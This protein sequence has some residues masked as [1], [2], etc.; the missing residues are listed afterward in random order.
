M[1]ENIVASSGELP[2]ENQETPVQPPS[3]DAAEMDSGEAAAPNSILERVKRRTGAVFEKAGIVY[4]R[5]GGRPRKD[6]LPKISDIPINA[7]GTALPLDTEPPAP[8]PAPNLDP[9]LVRRCCTAVI[10]AAKGF[11]DRH[12]FGKARIAGLEPSEAQQL[13]VDTTITAE[14]ADAFSELAEI[15][16]RK[17]GVGSEFAPEVAIAAI[18]AGIGIRYVNAIERMEEIAKAK[19][20]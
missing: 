17:Y 1:D 5:G 3:P 16:L 18:A 13:V 9:I 10:K 11:L 20:G 7:P 4:K 2:L 14:E 19:K 12:I 6:G 15:C 8:A